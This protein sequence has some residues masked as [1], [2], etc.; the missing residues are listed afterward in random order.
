MWRILILTPPD[1]AT[2][3]DDGYLSACKI[4]FRIASADNVTEVGIGADW[5]ILSACNRAGA[6]AADMIEAA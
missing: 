6:K 1:N 5:V 4:A 2:P 3:E